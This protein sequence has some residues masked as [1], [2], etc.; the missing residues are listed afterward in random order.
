MRVIVARNAP[1]KLLNGATAEVIDID[2]VEPASPGRLVKVRFPS[3]AENWQMLGD[4]LPA[5]EKAV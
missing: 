5:K 3:G 4:L 2:Y 1:H